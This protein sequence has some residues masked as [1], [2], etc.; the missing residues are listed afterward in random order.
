MSAFDDLLEEARLAGV[1]DDWLD[2][3]R[4]ASDGSPLRQENKTLKEQYE[5]A[6]QEVQRYRKATIGQFLAAQGF[7]GKPDAL[8][9]PADIDPLDQQKVQ[10]WAVDMG[11]IAPPPPSTEEEQRQAELQAHERVDNAAAGA[12]PIPA[13]QNAAR[14]KALSA[15]T[16][17]EF[18]RLAAEAGAVNPQQ[19]P[20]TP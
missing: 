12:Q 4:K 11:L 2:R 16:P 10:E 18:W 8:N 7:Q 17:A 14:E 5:Q 3:L 20:N 19:V 15:A 6:T 9:I 1:Q 13:G